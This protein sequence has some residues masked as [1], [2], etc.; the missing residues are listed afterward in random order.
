MKQFKYKG[1]NITISSIFDFKIKPLR[2]L[3]N[4]SERI[5][6]SEEPVSDKIIDF[7]LQS[8]DFTEFIDS[9]IN[10]ILNIVNNET[11]KLKRLILEVKTEEKVVKSIKLVA[12]TNDK[13]EKVCKLSKCI[14]YTS[15]DNNENIQSK[16]VEIM[17]LLKKI[18]DEITGKATRL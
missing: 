13:L 3:Y 1:L 6:I 2:L 10:D 9:S 16:G 7:L 5:N 17:N 11:Y 8:S 15:F 4:A 12:I 18:E 14:F